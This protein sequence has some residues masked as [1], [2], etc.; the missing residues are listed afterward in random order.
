[1]NAKRLTAHRVVTTLVLLVSAL[2]GMAPLPAPRAAHAATPPPGSWP[3]YRYDMQ[4]TNRVPSSVAK[5]NI[6]Q[7]AIKWTYPVGGGS[8]AWAHDITGPGGLPDGVPEIIAYGGERVRAFNS[9]TGD[10]I[11]T[12]DL[13]LGMVGAALP[14]IGDVDAD[15]QI[16]VL[17]QTFNGTDPNWQIYVLSG[18]MGQVRSRISGLELGPYPWMFIV[19]DATAD[20]K[21]EVFELGSVGPNVQVFTFQSGADSPQVIANNMPNSTRMPAVADLNGDG[22]PE[23]IYPR[24]GIRQYHVVETNSWSTVNVFSLPPSSASTLPNVLITDVLASFPGSEIISVWSPN[25]SGEAYVALHRV[26]ATLSSPLIT[27]WERFLTVGESGIGPV[28]APQLDGA[29]DR[30]IV[31]SYFDS[32]VGIWKTEVIQSSTGTTI[33]TINNQRLC[34]H[35]RYP[36]W[37]RGSVV[38]QANLDLNAADDEVVLCEAYGITG[39]NINI[40]AYDWS[41]SSLVELWTAAGAYPVEANEPSSIVP[42]AL[43]RMPRFTGRFN[44]DAVEDVLVFQ[45]GTLKVL[46]GNTGTPVYTYTPPVGVSVQYV[47][48]LDDNPATPEVLL[49]GADGYL[50]YLDRTLNLQRRIYAGVGFTAPYVVDTNSDNR[51]EVIFVN[52]TGSLLNIDPITATLKLPPR[53]NWAWGVALPGYWHP[54]NL[55]NAGLWEY[56]IIDTS[57]APTY[58]L[59]LMTKNPNGGTENELGSFSFPNVSNWLDLYAVGQFD[60]TGYDDII[61]AYSGYLVNGPVHALSWTGSALS[62]LWSQL[63]WTLNSRPGAVGQANGDAAEDVAW[64]PGYARAIINGANGSLLASSGM[65]AGAQPIA[66]NLDADSTLEVIFAAPSNG[67]FHVAEFSS[68]FTLVFTRTIPG[69]GGGIAAVADVS[70]SE[71]GLKIVYRTRAGVLG[72]MSGIDGSDIYT[73]GLGVAFNTV[74]CESF[75]NIPA[76]YIGSQVPALEALCPGAARFANLNDL[77]VADIDNDNKDEILASSDNGYLYALNAENGSL[78]WAYNFYYPVGAVRVANLD[79]D[80]QLEILVSVGDGFLYA[81]DQQSFAKPQSAWDGPSAIVNDDIDVQTSRLC[82]SGHWRA[83]SDPNLGQPDGYRIALRDEGGSLM[84]NGYLVV[85]HTVGASVMGATLCVNDPNPQ[86]ALLSPLTPGRRY[87]LEVISYKGANSSGPTFTDMVRIAETG[88]LELSSK[89]VTP[90]AT[91]PGGVI[92]WTIVVRNTGVAPAL[93]EVIDPIPLN[94]S[95]VAGSAT[96]SF[97]PPPVY[98]S[99][100]NRITWQSGT[101]LAVG[102]A[103]T[104]TFATQ[105]NGDFVSGLI[106]NQAEVID[107]DTGLRTRVAAAASVG[108]SN[109]SSAQKTVNLGQAFLNDTLIYTIRVTNTGTLTATGTLVEDPLPGGV[110]YQAGSMSSSGG[111][112]AASYDALSN[113]VLWT[114]SLGPG[115][116]LTVTFAAKVNIANGVIDNCATIRDIQNGSFQR[117]A[118]TVAGAGGPSLASSLKTSDRLVYATSDQIT[119]T[120]VLVNNGTQNAPNVALRDPLPAGVSAIF[121]SATGGSLS[122][123]PGLVQWNGGIPAGGVVNIT[124]VGNLSAPD[125]VLK[126]TAVVTDVAAN[127]VYT[128][129]REVLV[130]TAPFINAEKFAEPL[131]VQAGDEITYVMRLENIGNA[132]AASAVLSD[133]LPIGT[134]YVVG[135]AAANVG[136]VSYNAS[137]Q[138]LEWSGPIHLTQTTVITWRVKVEANALPGSVIVNRAYAYDGVSD[139]DEMAAVTAVNI[140][141]GKALI[142]G[143]VYSGTGTTPLPGVLLSAAGLVTVSQNTD[144]S[145]YAGLLVDAQVTP[146]NYVVYQVVPSGYVNLTPNPVGV[147]G[148][149]AGGVYDVVFRDA[150]AAPPGFGW[151]R[152]VVFNDVNGDGLRNI[153]SEVGLA[154]VTVAASDGQSMQTLGDGSYFFL[155]PAG[156]R[157]VT[158]TNLAGWVSTTPDV[159]TLNVASQGAHEVNFGDQLCPPGSPIC[160]PPQPGYAWLYGYVYRDADAVLNAPDGLKSAADDALA[161]VDAWASIGTFTGSDGTDANGFYYLEVPAGSGQ[162]TYTLPAGYIALTPPLVPVNAPDGGRVRVDFGVISATQCAA[163]TGVVNGFVYSDTFQNGQFI[164]G[165]DGPTLGDATVGYGGQTQQ[166]NWMYAFVCVP[167]GSGTVTSTNPAGYTNTTPNSVNVTVPDGGS[168]SA[169]FGKAF[170]QIPIALRYAYVPIVF[171][172]P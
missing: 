113:R 134:S 77:V 108:S 117:C 166:T 112:G 31:F 145:G 135:S 64:M 76:S 147:P 52:A 164:L 162:V 119:Y 100:N 161:S 18:S 141:A 74:T 171:R 130:G 27:V 123:T 70:L 11:W 107:M 81:L 4:R 8:S 67:I 125:G 106:R 85:T 148:V 40:H 73:R 86:R 109:L 110:V 92:T 56:P 28:I 133:P 169:N 46:D 116:S 50:Y 98:D 12:S 6:T 87:F 99:T 59:K 23:V 21:V 80:P 48:N 91:T 1:M 45:S 136:A 115:Q 155:L 44:L 57:Q 79:A 103:V 78:L 25:G 42:Y 16:E 168:V 94:T 131:G 146:T 111:S 172:Q 149:V 51:N 83:T 93:A 75:N 132:V 63:Y 5:G 138:R 7:P 159:V 69:S 32:G 19:T 41:G 3:F 2:L 55:D 102:Q 157:T 88:N 49:S 38:S 29:G 124:I 82:Y 101:P 126:N 122:F 128:L 20:G 84:T 167:A 121:A 144:G 58:T 61:I 160:A 137:A 150:L 153:F 17:I 95:Y 151:V 13:L 139:S 62:S 105:V 156:A 71:P 120:I 152:G 96:A 143:Y 24:E 34:I 97:G 104:I 89:A 154:G 54:L 35:G 10:P 15:G 9:Q 114:G 163:G 53:V 14:F 47:G 158:Q 129:T 37:K 39:G 118:R 165:V 30:E 140:P 43:Q 65:D 127:R 142:R 170:Q 33:Q 60:G 26:G 66:A 90:A 22:T 36:S 68:A 72:T